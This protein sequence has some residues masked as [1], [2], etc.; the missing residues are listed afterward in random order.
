MSSDDHRLKHPGV[1][2][3]SYRVILRSLERLRPIQGSC[4]SKSKSSLFSA[5]MYVAAKLLIIS[6][7]GQVDFMVKILAAKLCFFSI[8]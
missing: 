7:T 8:S 3:Q 1:V 5:T 6:P 4:L 2:G